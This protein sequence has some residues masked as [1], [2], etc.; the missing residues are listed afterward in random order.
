LSGTVA[1]STQ[2]PQSKL[3]SDERTLFVQQFCDI[4]T[5]CTTPLSSL[6]HLDISRN[7]FGFQG[8][9]IIGK[10]VSFYHL[11]GKPHLIVVFV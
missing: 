9:Q 5:S 6:T 11:N 2:I 4:I 7:N 3:E 10:V 1:S 8:A